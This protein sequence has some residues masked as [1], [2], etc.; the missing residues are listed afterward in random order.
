[1]RQSKLAA[2]RP[3]LIL[4]VALTGFFIAGRN[5]LAKRNIDQEVLI[6]GNLLLVSVTVISYLLFI[7]S[8][9]STNPN[10]FVR[11]MYGSFIL[12]FFVIA[13]AAFI[14][15][16]VTKSSVNKGALI[17]CMIL[18]LLYTFIEVSVLLKL[19]KKNKNA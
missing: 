3:I 13:I 9:K 5:F 11:A 2:I 19:M 17:V 1:M 10:A 16:M 18:Y 4:F 6:A 7:R 12:K 15:I 14:Y 8:I